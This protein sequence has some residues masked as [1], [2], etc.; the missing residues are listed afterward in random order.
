VISTLAPHI[1]GFD[2]ASLG[3]YQ[4]LAELGYDPATFMYSNPVKS[5]VHIKKTFE[6]GVRHYAFD[7]LSEITKLKENAPGSTVYLRLK[8]SDYGSKF[9]LSSKFGIEPLHAL[10]YASAAQDAGLQMKGLTFHVGSQSENPQVWVAALKI[11][12]KQIQQLRKAGITIEF[13]D[14]GGGFPA[15]YEELAT[16]LHDIAPIINE[17]IKQYIPE[18][19]RIIAEPGRYMSANASVMAASVIGREH[20]RGT[21]WLY[22]DVGVFQGLLEPLEMSDWRYPLFFDKSQSGYKKSFVLTGPSCDAYDTLGMDYLLPSDMNIGDKVYIG[23]VGAY[24]LVYGSNFNGF[25]VPKNY[26]L[27]GGSLL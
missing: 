26:F 15:E 23:A 5:P 12:G 13:V 20:R 6:G 8:V 9:P 22:L 11:V 17:A 14:M 4:Q 27:K 2:I 10:A 16:T 19:I 3:E 25:T 21:D 7:S 18:D 24:S 1:H